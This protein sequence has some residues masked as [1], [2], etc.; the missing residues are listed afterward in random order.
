MKWRIQID[1][2]RPGGG[3]TAYAATVSKPRLPAVG[4]VIKISGLSFTLDFV[5]QTD[6]TEWQAI[7]RLNVGTAA[8][9]RKVTAALKEAEFK[10]T[11]SFRR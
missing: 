3:V 2:Y 11:N 9:L 8:L 4:E 6:M 7:S 5:R 10:V 1:L